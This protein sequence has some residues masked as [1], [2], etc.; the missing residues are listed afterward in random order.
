MT[1][2][3]E[4]FTGFHQPDQQPFPFFQK[5]PVNTLLFFGIS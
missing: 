2:P 1:I 4:R 3:V 5:T